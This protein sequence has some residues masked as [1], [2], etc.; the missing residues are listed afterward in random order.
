MI[1]PPGCRVT[2]VAPPAAAGFVRNVGAQDLTCQCSP[3]LGVTFEPGP[4]VWE[5]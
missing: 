2:P 5:V 3:N 4:N 1:M